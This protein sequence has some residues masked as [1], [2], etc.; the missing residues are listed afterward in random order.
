MLATPAPL[1]GAPLS[2]APMPAAQSAS[3][4]LCGRAPISSFTRLQPGAVRQ[5]VGAG[6]QRMRCVC[7]IFQAP[8]PP[9]HL[10]PQPRRH[11][12]PVRLGALVVLQRH[13]ADEVA[14]AG[15]AKVLAVGRQVLVQLHPGRQAE[16]DVKL[17]GGS[18]TCNYP[19]LKECQ[20]S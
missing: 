15:D 16:G 7:A 20:Q 19:F 1:P 13:L 3:A 2:G 6:V 4:W 8:S 5:R 17:Y 14:G 10:R 9:N 12:P 11:A 18:E